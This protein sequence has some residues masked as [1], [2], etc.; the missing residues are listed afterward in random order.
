MVIGTNSVRVLTPSHNPH[1]CNPMNPKRFVNLVRVVRF[2]LLLHTRRIG[3]H[4]YTAEREKP[5]RTSPPS[6]RKPIC[7]PSRW[8]R[9]D[10]LGAVIATK[11][12]V[13][14][15]PIVDNITAITTRNVARIPTV[16]TVSIPVHVGEICV[17]PNCWPIPSV[18]RVHLA[19]LWRTPSTT[20]FRSVKVA[21]VGT[22][23]TFNRFAT[24]VT[25][26]SPRANGV[27]SRPAGGDFQTMMDQVFRRC[28]VLRALPQVR[29]GEVEISDDRKLHK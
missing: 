5:S 11:R 29:R 10:I 26:Q 6:P 22:G 12:M 17:K 8:G 3:I 4:I 7:R 9:A 23:T 1:G 24:A 21:I 27:D 20:S 16:M 14:A 28:V 13:T 15:R 18:Q 2:F 19:S 25:R